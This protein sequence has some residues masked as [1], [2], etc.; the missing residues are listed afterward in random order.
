MDDTEFKQ[1]PY[2]REQIRTTAAKCRFCGEWL[3]KPIEASATPASVSSTATEPEAGPGANP[4]RTEPPTADQRNQPSASLMASEHQEAVDLM[5]GEKVYRQLREQHN[6]YPTRDAWEFTFLKERPS[7]T[8]LTPAL[9]VKIWNFAERAGRNPETAIPKRK[10][11]GIS[12]ADDLRIKSCK[13]SAS[14]AGAVESLVL[15]PHSP[16]GKK[17][18]YF[19]RHWRGDLSLGVSYWV[20]GLLISFFILF[21]VG[22]LTVLLGQMGLRIIALMAL[23]LYALIMLV[24]VWQIV[25]IWRSASKHE[26][27]GGRRAWAIAAKVVVVLGT[28]SLINSIWTS[29]LPQSAEFARILGGDKAIESYQIKIVQEGKVVEFI[30]GLRFGCARDFEKILAAAPDAKYVRIES[31]GGRVLEAEAIAKLIQTRGLNTCTFKSCLSAATLVLMAGKDRLVDQDAKI[32]FHMGT[33]PGV[34]SSQLAEMN[35]AIASFMRSANIS[36]TFIRRVQA[37]PASQ[38]WYPTIKEMEAAGVITGVIP[39][40]D[41]AN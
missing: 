33:F 28:V 30:G 34:P 31:H 13:P 17:A 26:A 27:R 29:Y 4:L 25:G 23:M 5:L 11:D 10:M 2:C 12:S 19:V 1:C 37:T 9:L 6:I 35:V 15:P 18:N 3:E 32:G 38:M 40:D 39:D 7:A 41:A 14:P 36:E 24:N 22:V 8:P 16:T 20:N 21:L